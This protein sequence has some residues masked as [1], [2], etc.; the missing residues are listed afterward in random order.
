MDIKLLALDGD[1]SFDD[2]PAGTI[3]FQFL[4][5][6]HDLALRILEGM[7]KAMSCPEARAEIERL[8]EMIRLSSPSTYP[9]RTMVN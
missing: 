6:E 3:L 2:V 5:E 1:Y 9:D 7:H 8:M 4:P